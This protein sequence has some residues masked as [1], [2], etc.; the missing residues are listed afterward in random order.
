M[1]EEEKIK[2]EGIKGVPHNREPGSAIRHKTGNW[3]VFKPTIDHKKCI[4]CKICFTFC[5]DSAIK[6]INNKPII[7][8]DVCK[9]CGVCSAECPVKCIKMIRDLHEGRK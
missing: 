1:I 8:Y 3:R 9:G 7:D 5:P 4:S 6:W 2:Y